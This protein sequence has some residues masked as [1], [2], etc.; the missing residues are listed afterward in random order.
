MHMTESQSVTQIL[1]FV[2]FYFIFNFL[3]H[4]TCSAKVPFNLTDQGRE[5]G[6][7]MNRL[8]ELFFKYFR[9]YS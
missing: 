1:E 8:Y 5:E 3:C 6:Q 2:I 9:M 7:L 4:V